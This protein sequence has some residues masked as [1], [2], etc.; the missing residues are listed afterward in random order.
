MKLPDELYKILKWIGLIAIPAGVTFISTIGALWGWGNT[1]A[2]T[3][4]IAALG[5]L[6]GALIGI[7]SSNYYHIDKR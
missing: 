6:I 7:S 1:E 3:G 2:I 5:V 4:T